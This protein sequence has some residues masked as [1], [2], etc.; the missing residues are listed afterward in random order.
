MVL[1]VEGL[2][3]VDESE[4]WLSW[5][6]IFIRHAFGNYRDILREVTFSPMMTTYLTYHN[7]RAYTYAKT[8]PDENYA[9]EVMQRECHRIPTRAPCY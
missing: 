8:N 5:Y 2:G 6:D 1:G 3:K 9:R 4:L 7:N